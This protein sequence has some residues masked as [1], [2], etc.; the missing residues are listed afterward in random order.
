MQSGAFFLGQL[1]SRG[2]AVLGAPGPRAAWGGPGDARGL[3]SRGDQRW[4]L[5]RQRR[6]A[7]RGVL[8]VCGARARGLA[9]PRPPAQR[10]VLPEG[11]GHLHPTLRRGPGRELAGRRA[12]GIPPD[13]LRRR[14]GPREVGPRRAGATSLETARQLATGYRRRGDVSKSRQERERAAERQR[15]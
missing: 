13:Y 6:R 2:D 10:R 8:R 14:G 3:L 7:G 4:V 15:P 5:A 11:Y 1:R 9:R 12:A